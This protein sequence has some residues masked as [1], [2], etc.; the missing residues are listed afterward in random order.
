MPANKQW[1][2]MLSDYE[3]PDL[4]SG[5]DEALLEYIA[6]RKSEFADRDY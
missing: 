6:K 2:Q 4:D 5:I 3:A 1:K